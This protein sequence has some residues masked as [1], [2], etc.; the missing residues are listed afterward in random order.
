MEHTTKLHPNYAQNTTIKFIKTIDFGILLC[1]ISIVAQKFICYKI[2]AKRK[3]DFS[4]KQKEDFK[5]QLLSEART[6]A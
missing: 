3:T 2:N 6:S 1:I 4:I 5:W